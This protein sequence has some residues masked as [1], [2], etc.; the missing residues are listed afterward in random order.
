LALDQPGMR[1][2]LRRQMRTLRGAESTALVMLAGTVTG[3]ALQGGTSTVGG[4]V[5]AVCAV[6]LVGALAVTIRLSQRYRDIRATLLTHAWRVVD[7]IWSESER[8]RSAN[9]LLR[10]PANGE[11]AALR[12]P[13]AARPDE[14]VRVSLWFAGDLRRGGVVTAAGGGYLSYVRPHRRPIRRQIA[15]PTRQRFEYEYRPERAQAIARMY[16]TFDLDKL[17]NDGYVPPTPRPSEP[18]NTSN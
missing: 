15:V 17:R 18:A 16:E 1:R 5:A 12:T 2:A 13:S 4:Y 14:R 11:Q 6:V 8:G 10:D 7:G 3:A 9:V